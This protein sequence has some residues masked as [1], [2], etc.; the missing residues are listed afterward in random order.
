MTTFIS[1]SQLGVAGLIAI[2][3]G[4]VIAYVFRLLTKLQHDALKQALE[5]RDEATRK[6]DEQQRIMIPV[7][8]DVARVLN[9][10]QRM[11]QQREIELTMERE[12]GRRRGQHDESE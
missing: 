12:L 11:L 8:G 7:L 10:V 5:D 4:G 6:L 2:T 1:W 3:L 9:E